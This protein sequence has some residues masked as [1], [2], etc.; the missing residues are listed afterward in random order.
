C[1]GTLMTDLRNAL[2]SL[3]KTPAFTVLAVA[4]LALGIGAN[5]AVFTVLNTLLLKPLPYPNAKELVIVQRKYPQGFGNSV[6]IPKFNAWRK[7]NKVLDHMA[8]FDMGGPG[9]NLRGADLPELVRAIHVSYEYFPLFGATAA[10]G[11]TFSADED[12]PGGPK[13]AILSHGL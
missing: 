8:A 10:L 12:K 13:V 11:R 3:L 2:R 4:V 9:V 5:A 1:S 7:G 6:S